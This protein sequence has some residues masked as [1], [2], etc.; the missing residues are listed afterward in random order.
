MGDLYGGFWGI[1]TLGNWKFGHFFAAPIRGRGD[2]HVCSN[3]CIYISKMNIEPRATENEVRV[4]GVRY[5][6]PITF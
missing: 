3:H 4:M 1:L 6:F 5:P 2:G